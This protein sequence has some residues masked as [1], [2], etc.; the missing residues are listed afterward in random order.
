MKADLVCQSKQ[1]DQT[2]SEE[3]RHMNPEVVDFIEENKAIETL[4]RGLSEEQLTEPTAFKEWTTEHILKHLASGNLGA[5]MSLTDPERF[6]AELKARQAA[7]KRG[8]PSKYD[9]M[10]GTELIDGWMET[11]DDIVAHFGE[12]DLS[13]RVPWAK[14]MS[15]RSSLSARMME[16]WS[17]A[18]AIYDQ[19][20]VE[21]Q[22]TDR[23]KHVAILCVNTYGWTF[24]NAK[25]P[26]PEPKPYVEL[27]APS[28]D[29]WSFGEKSDSELVRGSATEFCQVCTQTRNVADT[30]LQ[31]VGPNAT[32]W[33]ASAQCFAGPPHPPPAP[34]TRKIN[35][36][37]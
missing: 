18:Q 17:H 30:A 32:A 33:M 11:V 6:M 19:F 3:G 27:T 16:S 22:D 15:A 28:G 2:Q 37:R 1:G 9:D 35:R 29:T 13:Q 7:G 26:I 34:G 21:R 8:M 24:E 20:G 10:S 36:N 25:K 14:K 23:L 12:A 31:V 4:V 5:V